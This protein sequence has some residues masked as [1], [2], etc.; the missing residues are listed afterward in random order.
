MTFTQ[1][2]IF[3]LVA[4]LRGFTA[5]ATQLSISQSA[6]SH[7]LKSLERELGVDLIKRHQAAIEVTEIGRQLLGR[8]RE[9]LGLS[10]AMRQEVIDVTAGAGFYIRREALAR[11]GVEPEPEPARV[12]E[13]FEPSDDDDLDDDLESDDDF[14]SDDED[15][16]D[17]SDDDDEL[18]DDFEDDDSPAEAD[19]EGVT[20]AFP[21]DDEADEETEES[22]AAR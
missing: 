3:V 15:E 16:E 13:K 8:A 20:E 11:L 5:A 1:L 17:W 12:I 2:E 21:H 14:E 6:V 22:E 7:A 4:E 19:D 9:I 18:T 10:E